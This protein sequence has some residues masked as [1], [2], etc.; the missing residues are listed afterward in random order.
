MRRGA[1][2]YVGDDAKNCTGP[3]APTAVVLPTMICPSDSSGSFHRLSGTTGLSDETI[4]H[5]R[6][7]YAV[8]F[9]NLDQGST[10]NLTADHL[11]AAF[12]FRP[13][14]IRDIRDGTS[15]TMA[16]G[17][18]LRDTDDRGSFRGGYWR[19]FPGASWIFTLNPPNSPVPDALWN[20]QCRAVD[21]R[22]EQNLPCVPLGG[23]YE[24]AASRSRHPGGVQVGNCD[25]SVHFITNTVPLNVWR[26]MGSIDGGETVELP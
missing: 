10:L 24:T 25:G 18:M 17:E 15:K 19:D 4:F 22:P 9:G 1:G 20:S 23:N 11:P 12:G 2:G 8:F 26:A 5:A 16:F 3:D 7:N 6:G 13:V 14:R 21:N